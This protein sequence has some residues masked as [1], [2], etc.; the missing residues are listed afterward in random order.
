MDPSTEAIISHLNDKDQ[1]NFIKLLMTARTEHEIPVEEFSDATIMRF[2][3]QSYNKVDP[4]LERLKQSYEWRKSFNFDHVA[5]L[6]P[7]KF[8]DLQ[9]TMKMHFCGTDKQGR[10]VRI[11]QV[12]D[13]DPDIVVD[14]FTPEEFMMHNVAYVERLINIIFERCTQ[15]AG[16]VIY[17]TLTI[18][19]IKDFNVNKFI[20]SSKV[21]QF[22]SH[23][24]KVF[25]ANYPEMA[26]HVFV[27]NAGMFMKV[28]YNFF[29]VFLDKR[30]IER[31]TILDGDYMGHLEKY[32]DKSVLPKCIGG[33]SPHSIIEYP[34][35]WDEDIE[36]ALKNNKLRLEK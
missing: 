3:N 12:P 23:Q 18:V 27:I 29:T 21:K 16:K 1:I 15:K 33:D 7:K 25:N 9:N 10:P 22:M 17:K 20:F 13:L 34:N 35:F 14:M 8:Q 4:A 11:T 31:I 24:S 2:F 36:Y 26:A 28:L 19:D 32:I 30:V 5:Q 6:D